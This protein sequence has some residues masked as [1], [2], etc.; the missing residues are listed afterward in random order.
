LAF[1]HFQLQGL[2]LGHASK[3]TMQNFLVKPLVLDNFEPWLVPHA[4]GHV[5]FVLTLLR[6]APR[7]TLLI[8]SREGLDVQA[9]HELQLQGLDYPAAASE[10]AMPITQYPAAQLFI[11]RAL[12][13]RPQWRQAEPPWTELGEICRQVQGL[14]LALEL[15]ASWARQ[16][17]VAEIAARLRCDAL[18]L[19]TT[20]R[21]V[22]ERHHSLRVVLAQSWQ[23][24]TA[25][26]QCVLRR[27]SVFAGGWT[28][29]AAEAV[30]GDDVGAIHESPLQSPLQPMD[31]PHV[32]TRLVDKSLVVWDGSASEDAAPRYRMGET[33]RQYAHEQL[34]DA[35]ESEQL[36]DQHLRF[37]VQLVEQVEPLLNTPQ[38]S[39][40]LPRLT[41]EH[42]NL[43]AALA[44]ACERDLET[45]RWLAGLLHWFWY[46]G[47][48]LHEARTWYARVLDTGERGHATRGLAMALQ[49]SGT[50]STFLN[51]LDEAQSPLEQSIVLWQQLGD[52]QRLAWSLYR[53]TYLLMQRGDSARACATYAEHESLFRASGNSLL[54][55]LALSWWARALIELRRDALTA[56]ALL[57][58]ALSL[59]RAQQDPRSLFACY[60]SLG[61]WALAQG[62]HATARCHQMESLRWRRQ[63]GTHWV[64]LIGLQDVAHVMCLQGDYQS[65]EPVYV[66]ALALTRM[67]GDQ[68]SEASLAQQ[69]AEVAL[70]LGNG[71][72]A[73]RINFG[74]G[75]GGC[76]ER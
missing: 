62:A 1:F 37:F 60:Q 74:T 9:A 19:A 36:R 73:S 22:P 35:H 38:C 47:D 39:T 50:V 69:L 27:L 13:V 72:Q 14:P 42:D 4:S 33:I 71:E 12:R 23:R 8:T 3:H 54:L 75:G 10:P 55:V 7:V 49:G 48:H 70:H 24:L 61:S 32:L 66:E 20:L 45:A 31:I 17:S 67:I 16:W 68:R 18:A 59:G 41:V 44:W 46:Y 57:D 53:L 52:P 43:R 11:E 56:K 6:R 25:N 63:W 2:F 15:A 5:D 64:I 51:Y 26:E 40:W 29:E 65:A 34:L 28:V 30:C 21:D 58:E 76:V